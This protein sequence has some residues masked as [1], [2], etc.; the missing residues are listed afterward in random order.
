MSVTFIDLCEINVHQ[1][2]RLRPVWT[3]IYLKEAVEIT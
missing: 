3:A 1:G 2:M